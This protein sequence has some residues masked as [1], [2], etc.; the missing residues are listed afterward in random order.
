[1]RKKRG[2]TS[3]LLPVLLCGLA[4]WVIFRHDPALLA[5]SKAWPEL[6]R[7]LT[8]MLAF[9]GVG[10]V[11]GLAVEGMGWSAWLAAA[12][13]PLMRFGRL[14]DASG[15]AF[16]TAFFSGTAA[17]A[18]LMNAWRDGRLGEREMRLSY[19]VNTG[20]PVFLLHLPTTFFVV[21]PM[22]RSAGAIYLALNALAAMLRTLGVLAWTRATLHAAPAAGISAETDASPAT[23]TA[24]PAGDSTSQN[25]GR[26]TDRTTPQKILAAFRNRFWRIVTITVPIYLL[27][28][29]LNQTGV[30]ENL[31][32]MAAHW[33]VTGLLPVEAVSVVVFAVAAEFT[34]G[35]AAAGALL[36]AGSLTTQQAVLALVLG[37]IVATPIRA[38]RHQ[39]PA[40]AGVFTPRLGLVMLLQSQF[41][42]V[43]SLLLVTAGYVALA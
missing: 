38:I 9:L 11:A 15:A 35:I 23:A 13:R 19:L 12:V 5:W 33:V 6:L 26:N 8:R 10:L 40:H 3:L 32:D 1:M 20:L 43:A 16:A 17:N 28:Y 36:D 37:T 4:L 30:F 22:T 14:R 41:L 7:P 25:T 24:H 18:M 34:S 31:R 39:L 2:A 21:V 42:R 27:M 29:A